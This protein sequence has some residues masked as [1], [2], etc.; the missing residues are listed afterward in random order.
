M[1]HRPRHA[2]RLAR[3]R[4]WW[5]GMV[6]GVLVAGLVAWLAVCVDV[7]LSPQ[8]DPQQRVDAV[9]VIG[10]AETRIDQA[11]ALMDDGLAPVLLATTSVKDSGE[12]Y[13]TGHCGT[14]APTYRVECVLPDPYTTRGEAQVLG[15]KVAA[16]G[17]TRVAVLT[18]TAHVPR[19]RMLMERC[20]D[21]EVLMWGA[22]RGDRS[23]VGVL[24]TFIYQS[25]AWAKAQLV[26]GC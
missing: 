17:W 5:A 26:R 24:E 9:Y 6:V 10:P 19:T 12:T 3:T 25:A 11:L 18:R 20:T 1:T 7:L 2:A 15:E 16:H 21:A 8:I 14:V 4:P 13:E 22:D 23:I